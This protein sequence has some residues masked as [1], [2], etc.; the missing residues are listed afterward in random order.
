VPGRAAPEPSYDRWLFRQDEQASYRRYADVLRLIG[1]DEPDKRWLLKNPGHIATM[2]CLLEV[3]PDALIVQ[4]HRDP[5]Q[6][7]PSLCSTLHMARRMYEGEAARAEVIGPR[8]LDYWGRAIAATE[9][10]RC[11]HPERFFDVDHR[12]FHAD[13]LGTVRRIYR[14]F[15]LT[16]SDSA[17][18]RMQHRIAASAAAGPGVHR[19]RAS[20]YGL[21]EQQI[22]KTFADY[23]A[24]YRL[25]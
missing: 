17:R 15:E 12:E 7:V 20:S 25:S 19:Y 10:I 2:D 13:P 6:A 22:R 1:A 16:L 23:A 8:E 5:V 3:F 14:R 21:S 4:T 24:K 9:A 18:E 11:R